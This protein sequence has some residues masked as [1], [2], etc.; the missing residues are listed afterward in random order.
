MPST[1]PLAW[2]LTTIF[3]WKQG[4]KQEYDL[5]KVNN[6]SFVFHRTVEEARRGAM[7]T[8]RH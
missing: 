6:Q 7:S 2:L 4:Q 3:G 1:K 5:D 8:V